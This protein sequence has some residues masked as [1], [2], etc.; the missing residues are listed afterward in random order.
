M[1]LSICYNDGWLLSETHLSP[2]QSPTLPGRPASYSQP[3][4]TMKQSVAAVFLSA[5]FILPWGQTVL[6]LLLL[7][8]VLGWDELSSG[9]CTE[10]GAGREVLLMGAAHAVSQSV[11]QPVQPASGRASE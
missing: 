6:C 1:L 11:A 9:L 7:Q 5:F 8:Q 10:E 2:E 3:L 4:P